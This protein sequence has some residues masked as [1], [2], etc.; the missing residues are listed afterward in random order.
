MS[1]TNLR[2]L[3]CLVM[4]GGPTLAHATCLTSVTELKAEGIK[5][6]WQETTMDDG[7][8]LKI[9]IADGANGLVYSAS[10][11]GEPWLTGDAAFC[12]SGNTTTVTLDNTKATENVP[13]VT[14]MALPS[15]LSAPIVN[16]EIRLAGGAWRGTF[17]GR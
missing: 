6:N 4:L 1:P 5:T 13:L 11:A 17:V 16:D 2:L 12:R 9:V 3:V 8:P 15:T 7:K 10:K 14:R